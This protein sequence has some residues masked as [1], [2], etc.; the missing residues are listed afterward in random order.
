MVGG[1]AIGFV[2]GYFLK[3]AK[4]L[5]IALGGI[6]LLLGYLEYQKWISVNWTIVE[7]QTSTMMTRVAHKAYVITQQMGHKEQESIIY[8]LSRDRIGR[9]YKCQ[10]FFQ[11]LLEAGHACLLFEFS[12]SFT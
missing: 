8:C 5:V 4:L 2:T 3:I 10:L 12:L 6:A 11:T 1:G 7:N 9:I